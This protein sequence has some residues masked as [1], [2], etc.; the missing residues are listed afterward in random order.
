MRKQ[1]Q[2]IIINGDQVYLKHFKTK[3][4]ALQYCQNFMD[5]SKEIILRPIKNLQTF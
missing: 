1:Q 3:E 5:H 2:Y 4:E